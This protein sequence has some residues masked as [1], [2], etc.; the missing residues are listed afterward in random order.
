[1]DV[2]AQRLERVRLRDVEGE[3]LGVA[4]ESVRLRVAR[5]LRSP[6]LL[7][8]GV[9][10]AAN[11]RVQTSAETLAPG[12]LRFNTPAAGIMQTTAN[13]LSYTVAFLYAMLGAYLVA[14]LIVPRFLQPA[15]WRASY[16]DGT[17]VFGDGIDAPIVHAPTGVDAPDLMARTAKD[18]VLQ[19]VT[20]QGAAIFSPDG[21]MTVDDGTI[22]HASSARTWTIVLLVA[23]GLLAASKWNGAFDFVV[24]GVVVMTVWGQRFLRRRALYGNPRGFTPDVLLGSVAF[25]A[26]TIYALSYVPFF[27]LGH[28]LSDMLALQQ[29]MYWYHENVRATHPY[30]SV[31]WQWPIMQ[32]PISY[33]YHDSRIGAALQD[34]SKCCV[35]EI[36][37]LPN[38]LVFL[39]G[40]ISVPWVGFLAWRERN[41]GYALL[42]ATYFIQWIPWMRSPRL[43]FEYHFFPNLAMIVLC[44]AIVI[45]RVYA[46]IAK[47][48][49][50]WYLGGYAAAVVLMF[51]YF[52]P[53][54]AGVG[55]TYNAWHE[56]MWPDILGIP[57][58]SWIVPPR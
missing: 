38:P 46:S 27:A 30:S 12:L 52:Y 16:A 36:L 3:A 23:L 1:M 26:A 34:A 49:R 21:T 15:G 33:Y 48:N 57:H 17:V 22:V 44:N 20:P 6:V 53:V 18:G 24:V 7:D 56:R 42:F 14:R 58:T 32:V 13:S 10:L 37:A 8:S 35:A 55:V 45:Q 5:D 31:W 11:A 41:K 28:G 9:R 43:L 47:A 2:R 25:V 39:L 4:L 19:Y 51:A 40:L 29:Q 50:N 54:L